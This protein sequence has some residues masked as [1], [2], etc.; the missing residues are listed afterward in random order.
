L[1][2]LSG[3]ALRHRTAPGD[4]FAI[5]V[6]RSVMLFVIQM[7]PVS[8]FRVYWNLAVDCVFLLRPNNLQQIS[9]TATC[10]KNLVIS[11]FDDFC[12]P[13]P[14]IYPQSK[15]R[16]IAAISEHSEDV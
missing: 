15:K 9:N 13:Q 8:Q 11:E 16:L 5:P 7:Q 3:K 4:S 14:S 12:N 6:P 1:K 10:R 2:R